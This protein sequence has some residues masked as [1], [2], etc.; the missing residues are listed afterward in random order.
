MVE[1][2]VTLGVKLIGLFFSNQATKDKVLKQFLDFV[3]SHAGDSAIPV[4]KR[5]EYLELIK[6]ANESTDKK[7]E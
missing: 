5:E 7:A 4:K 1:F 6:K 3:A 2:I